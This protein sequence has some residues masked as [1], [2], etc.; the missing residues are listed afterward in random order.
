MI[1][2]RNVL[3][4]DTDLNKPEVLNRFIVETPRSLRGTIQLQ[5]KKESLRQ[6]HL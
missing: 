1:L 4:F 3:H 6:A 5:F 2:H